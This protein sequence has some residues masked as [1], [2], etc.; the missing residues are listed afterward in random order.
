M[1]T[2]IENVNTLEEESRDK[3][4]GKKSRII[5]YF[6]LPGIIPQAKELSRGGFGYLALLIAAVYQAVRILPKNHPYTLYDN[7][8]SFGIRQVIAE[9]ANHVKL[10][11]KNFDQAIVFFAVLAGIVI[12]CL[13]FI[14]FMLLLISGE[15]FAQ[16][17]PATGLFGTAYPE[18]DIAFNMLREVFGLPTMFGT[19]AGGPTPFHIA[20]QA[21]FQF[22]NFAILIVALVVF[23][24]YIIVVVAETAQTGT[25]FGQRFSHIYAPLRL[26][27]AIGLL[28]P[29]SY[30]YNGAQYITFYAAK[31]GSGFAS[32]GWIA[33]N[34]QLQASNPLG[35]DN[36]TLIAETNSPDPQALIE[37][38][39]TVVTCREAYKL[40]EKKEIKRFYQVVDPANRNSQINFEGSPYQVLN[41]LTASKNTND[42]RVVFGIKETSYLD[43]SGN[44]TA[45]KSATGDLIPYC[46]SV[47]IPITVPMA[48]GASGSFGMSED[49]VSQNGDPGYIQRIY[50]LFVESLWN[51]GGLK[52]LGQKIVNTYK[53]CEKDT[54]CDYTH[55]DKTKIIDI[56]KGDIDLLTKEHFT[57]AREKSDFS[58]NQDT[59]ERGWGGAGIWYNRIAQ[60]NGAYVVASMNIPT[61][62][63]YPLVMANILEQKRASDSDFTSCKAFE[64]NLANNKDIEY[65]RPIDSNYAQI[66]NATHQFLTCD[67]ERG[68]SNFII[69]TMAM[70][71][72]LNGLI[73][74]RD[75][76]DGKEISRDANDDPVYEKV[77][78]HPLAKL[79]ALGKGLIESAVRSLGFAMITSVGSGIFDQ[80]FGAGFK[81]ATSMFTSIATIG[82]SIGFITYYILP[83]LPFIYFFFAVGSWVKSIF[84]AMVG[85]PLWALAHLRI[86][87]DGIPGKMGMNGYFLILEIFLRPILTVFGLLGGMA[88]F[89]AMAA[90]L[91]EIFDVV[92]LNTTGVAI[93]DPDAA[94]FSRH[95]IDQFFFTIVYAIILYMMAMASFK[96]VTLVPNS[97]LRW[98][99]QNVSA[100]SDGAGDPTSGLINYAALGGARIGGQLADGFT[101]LGEAAGGVGGGIIASGR[102]A[103]GG[104]AT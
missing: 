28:V 36:V 34:D 98:I 9:A 101:K 59:K 102:S 7:M 16:V 8:G 71:F 92:V 57:A 21:M 103:G 95:T 91:N 100:F 40:K 104:T 62:Q 20:L 50:T 38:M 58:L 49:A 17:V 69:D 77:Q 35:A 87:G 61:G 78:I 65:D 70:I 68:A 23:V 13:Q 12:L 33:F 11:R 97:I 67:N 79:S 42:I 18:T 93:N 1:T 5:S 60:I 75:T 2:K 45:S 74:I 14:G 73:T 25:P 94:T 85:A 90:L 46:G 52:T 53:S 47:I 30:G 27:I 88:T 10:D 26:V 31:L 80:H 83:F 43:S 44:I 15:A 66:L 81:A 56:F 19:L 82:L 48:Q 24:Y 4:R 76:A 41:T 51:S 84:E 64:P 54:E 89:S 39:A 99:G 72:G 55:E 29:L 37:F 63:Q 6:L 32:T 86:D 96:M 3:R 22:Y